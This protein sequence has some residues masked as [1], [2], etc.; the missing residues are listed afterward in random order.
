M[1][2]RIVERGGDYLLAVKANQPTLY[3]ELDT[4]FA[5]QD[6]TLAGVETPVQTAHGRNEQRLAW[7]CHQPGE[8]AGD[9]PQ[10]ACVAMVQCI[11][12]VGQRQASEHRFSISNRALGA[13]THVR[14][15]LSQPPPPHGLPQVRGD[16]IVRG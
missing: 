9:W 7:V 3:G 11:R 2:E 6:E 10:A 1:A 4:L 16:G 8:V 12:S 13:G 5:E 14:G 15:L